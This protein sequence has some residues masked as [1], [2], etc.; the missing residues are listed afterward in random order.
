MREYF[1]IYKFIDVVDVVSARN[2]EEASKQIRKRL[3]SKHD[4][5]EVKEA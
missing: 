3:S 4:Y 5:V 1:I 2:R